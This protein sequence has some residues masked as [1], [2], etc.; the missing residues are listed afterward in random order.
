MRAPSLREA[1]RRMVESVPHW[2]GGTRIGESLGRVNSD[3]EWLLNRF[4]TVMLLSDGWE[5]G[6]P[7]GLARELRRMRR[8][9]GAWCGSIRCWARATTSRWRA[10]CAQPRRTWTT[11]RRR[12]T[13]RA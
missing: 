3:Y 4:T 1:L 8:G 5:T 6:D 7:E 12:G 13:W 2:S 9:F 11:S 10:G